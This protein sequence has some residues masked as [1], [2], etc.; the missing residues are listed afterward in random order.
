MVEKQLIKYIMPN[1]L[2]MVGISCYILADTFFISRAAGTNGIAALNLVLPFYGLIYALGAMIGVGSATR[3]SLLKASGSKMADYF[4]SNAII[5]ATFFGLILSALGIFCP[6]WLLRIMGADDTIVEVGLSY[7][8]I[9]MICSP[10]FIVNYIFTSFV[11][12][13]NAPNVAMTATI[14]SGLLNIAFDYI[15]MFPLNMGMAGAALATGL[16]P[17]V[18]MLICMIHFL[19]KKNNIKFKKKMPSFK[20]LVSG[21]QLGVVAFVGEISGGITTMAFN[22]ILL[23]LTGNIGVAAY[24]IVANITIVGMALLNGVAHGL[25]PLASAM[26]G[27]GKAEDESRIY[28]C[29]VKI[30]L[31]ISAVLVA[32]A[33]VFAK[34]IVAIFN[35]ENS[36]ELAGYA[37][38]GMRLYFLGYLVAAVN[39]VKAGFYSATGMAKEASVISILRGVIAIVVFAFLMSM[40]FG[41]TGVWL[42]FLVAEIFTLVYTKI[43]LERKK[44]ISI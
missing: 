19:S 16:S 21:C 27:E 43:F 31:L 15:L 24:G 6:E 26:H 22:F 2:A 38:P 10:F 34:D 12:N 29:S 18:S 30:A 23:N 4:F 3:Y 25:Q 42:S 44:K 5:W 41:I 37:E 14:A 1:T 13:D 40:L 8:R 28:K 9:F 35:S 33:L 36:T 32:V 11:R 7:T 39:L 20:R 17:V